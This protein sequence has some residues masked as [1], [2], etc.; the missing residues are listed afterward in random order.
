MRI[1]LVEDDPKIAASLGRALRAESYAVDSAG[2]GV[3]GEELALVNDYDLIILDIML[4][5]QDGWQTCA[6]LRHAHVQ[7]PVLM[8][9]ALDDDR[10]QRVGEVILAPVS[11]SLSPASSGIV[12][13]DDEEAARKA[14][15]VIANAALAIRLLTFI[16]QRGEK[17]GYGGAARRRLEGLRDEVVRRVEKL[18]ESAGA[19]ALQNVAPDD[20]DQARKLVEILF[21]ND[22]RGE[23]LGARLKAALK[24]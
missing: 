16:V 8:L 23:M 11:N 7:T 15:A 20:L 21:N 19:D 14:P 2:D 3:K 17:G 5:R 4:P 6:H 13:G 24:A 22:R 1:L 12:I 9:T 10:L 18:L